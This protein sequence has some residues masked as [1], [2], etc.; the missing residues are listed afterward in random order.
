MEE[1]V[2]LQKLISEHHGEEL[3]TVTFQLPADNCSIVKIE[4]KAS[5]II[6]PVG[7]GIIVQII[8]L[9]QLVVSCGGC[10]YIYQE[11]EAKE[12]FFY[13][14]YSP[15]ES[16]WESRCLV[17]KPQEVLAGNKLIVIV[18]CHVDL[19]CT[20]EEP[21][22][23]HPDPEA[24]PD[25]GLVLADI[26]LASGAERQ[27]LHIPVSLAVA[28]GFLRADI[29]ATTVETTIFNGE[30]IIS[31]QIA[32]G[33]Y[34]AAPNGTER[35]VSI[36]KDFTYLISHPNI[37]PGVNVQTN[38]CWEVIVSRSVLRIFLVLDWLISAKK[39]ISIPKGVVY[40]PLRIDR[41]IEETQT[42]VEF[43]ETFAIGEEFR[44][45]R[46]YQLTWQRVQVIIKQDFLLLTAEMILWVTG[47]TPFDEVKELVFTAPVQKVI[48]SNGLP[49][50]T[51]YYLIPKT[52]YLRL[53]ILPRNYLSVLGQV[54]FEV[55]A[56]YRETWEPA[57]PVFGPIYTEDEVTTAAEYRLDL[58]LPRGFTKIVKV[59]VTP[60]IT[61]AGIN[62]EIQ[63]SLWVQ[64]WVCNKKGLT[65]QVATSLSFW[66]FPPGADVELVSGHPAQASILEQG[67][68]KKRKRKGMR[69]RWYLQLT[70]Q[71]IF[72][73]KIRNWKPNLIP[74]G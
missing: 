46:D 73:F 6:H 67:V 18:P 12:G 16:Q 39:T 56:I 9:V 71:V 13:S 17:K 68:G 35:Y 8:V 11:G 64:A 50:E 38:Y 43:K 19:W 63:G 52:D 28:A 74:R 69:N 31:G 23:H 3:L 61:E 1:Q 62:G 58:A 14:I 37:E 70:I 34:Y 48:S 36:E 66:H 57:P 60:G 65:E 41:L 26:L 5:H 54:S 33:I 24:T 27:C 47:V 25:N 53:E 10:G 44:K 29:S 32:G 7:G 42:L 30:T 72:V 4:A 22:C 20:E 2:L 40:S 49:P 59:V 45:I 15:A 55:K 51:D 21:Y